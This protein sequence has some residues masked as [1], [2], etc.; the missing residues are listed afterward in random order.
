[1]R[2]H[3]LAYGYPLGI[4]AEWIS[5]YDYDIADDIS[6]LTLPF[7][8]QDFDY[9]HFLSTHPSLSLCRIFIPSQ[10]LLGM[11][12]DVLLHKKSPDPL[13]VR[14]IEP[15]ALGGFTSRSLFPPTVYSF[16]TQPMINPSHA[17]SSTNTLLSCWTVTQ[18]S[19]CQLLPLQVMN[20]FTRSMIITYYYH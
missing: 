4:Q 15:F 1:M 9:A 10:T 5:T 3:W 18:S 2:T 8:R 11:I 7:G 14:A 16:D 19:G 13:T 6:R 12:W 20:T 17:L